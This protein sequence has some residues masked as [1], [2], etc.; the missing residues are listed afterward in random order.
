M[1]SSTA[2]EPTVVSLSFSSGVQSVSINRISNDR[3]I[4]KYSVTIAASG[5]TA[6][7][8]AGADKNTTVNTGVALAATAAG[9]GKT[10]AWT[11]QSAP[12]GATGDYAPTFS[13]TSSATATFTPKVKGSYTLRWTVTCTEG[14]SSANDDMEVSVCAPISPTLDYTSTSLTVGAGNSSAPSLDKDGSSGTVTW[15]SSAPAKATVNSSGV[16]TPVAAGSAT[17][18]ATIAADAEN[19]Y[20]ANTATADFTISAAPVSTPVISSVTV[21][22]STVCVGDDITLTCTASNSPTSYTWYRN[23][24]ASTAG[25]T[26][27]GDATATNTKTTSTSALAAGTYYFYCVATNASGSSDPVFT[28]AVKVATK[29]GLTISLAP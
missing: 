5:C 16:V 29:P 6:T 26:S 11:V 4:V 17:I 19:H 23:T 14:E 20:C 8:N 18:T 25:A 10:G 24:S 9:D 22:N 7:A 27:L 3:F 2:A 28:S 13:S 21:D 1:N 15:E 12:D